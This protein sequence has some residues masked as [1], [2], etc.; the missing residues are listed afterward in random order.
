M[1]GI[2]WFAIGFVVFLW[3]ATPNGAT[4]MFGGL[5]PRVTGLPVSELFVAI[6]VVGFVVGYAWMWR[7]YRA[8]TRFDGA[9]WRFHDH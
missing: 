8:P 2:P 6:G 5:G 7:L 9:H 1:L 4:P 3:V